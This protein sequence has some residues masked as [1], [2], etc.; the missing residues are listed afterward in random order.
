MKTEYIVKT[1]LREIL[2]I[3]DIEPDINLYDYGMASIEIIRLIVRIEK[4]TGV[5]LNLIDT[6]KS[7][8]LK[9]ICEFIDKT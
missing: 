5:R 8:T 9:S 2:E 7:P 6:F 3:E 1:I 4:E